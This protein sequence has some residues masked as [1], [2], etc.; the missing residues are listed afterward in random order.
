MLEAWSRAT[1]SAMLCYGVQ[2]GVGTASAPSATYKRFSWR[3]RQGDGGGLR[4]PDS[5]P[6]KV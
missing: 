4:A 2:G 3:A 5:S 1:P 6:A